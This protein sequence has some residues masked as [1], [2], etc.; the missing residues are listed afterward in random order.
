MKFHEEEVALLYA[1]DFAD[2]SHKV[3]NS[4]REKID[5]GNNS[6]PLLSVLHRW[7]KKSLQ[8]IGLDLEELTLGKIQINYFN[9]D[10]SDIAI[11][12]NVR[13]R[14]VYVLHTF[15]GPDGEYSANDG[16]MNLYLVDDALR[17]SSAREITYVLPHIPYQRQDR[18][19]KPRVPI[20][21]KRTLSMLVPPDSKVP[22][23]LVTFDMHVGQIQGFVN[24]PLDH[25]NAT[26]LLVDYFM[27]MPDPFDVTI[28]S[29]DA[30]GVERVRHMAKKMK[31]RHIAIID[32][33]REGPGQS[34]VM[35]IVGRENI[36]GKRCIV[37][38]DL[39]DTGGT[40][41]NTAYALWDAGAKEVYLASTHPLFSQNKKKPELNTEEELRKSRMKVVA[42]D[43]IPKPPEYLHAHSDWLTVLSVA[44]MTAEA[45]YR[46]ETR[47]SISELIG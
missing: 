3:Y 39:V 23:R 45:I 12:D 9:N 46:I 34:E 5:S 24:D 35:N 27:Q 43:T 47:G 32:K 20:S 33:R 25:L 2:F 28:V 14:H 17:R 16:F 7:G 41:V 19:N 8:Y 6:N 15:T 36:N 21:A 30:G 11:L 18:M 42:A 26:N 37:R 38:D 29:P 31:T 4:L 1:Q 10:E 13:G 44:P 40:A 22:T